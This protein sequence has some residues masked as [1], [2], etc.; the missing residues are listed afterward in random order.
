MRMF[1]VH[2]CVQVMVTEKVVEQESTGAK[3]ALKRWTRTL[4]RAGTPRRVKVKTVRRKKI[5]TEPKPKSAYL[6][7]YDRKDLH[8]TPP[9]TPTTPASPKDGAV[10]ATRPPCQQQAAA[11]SGE[12]PVRFRKALWSNSASFLM[13]KMLFEHSYARKSPRVVVQEVTELASGFGLSLLLC[14]GT[15]LIWMFCALAGA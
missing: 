4:T 10:S 6:L 7:V 14:E 13:D 12:L 3:S 5:I 11:A 1:M 2:A 15:A 9:S 8:A